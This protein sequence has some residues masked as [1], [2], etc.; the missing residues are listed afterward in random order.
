[1]ET[2]KPM[3]TEIIY[4]T[5]ISQWSLRERLLI[6]IKGKTTTDVKIKVAFDAEKC[7][8][9]ESTAHAYTERL[10]ENKKGYSENSMQKDHE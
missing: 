6:L 2:N 8:P 7:Q 4:N 1:M 5:T 10:F 9:I 3:K